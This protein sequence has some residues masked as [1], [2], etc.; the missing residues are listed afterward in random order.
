[1]YLGMGICLLLCAVGS[2]V[3]KTVKCLLNKQVVMCSLIFFCSYTGSSPYFRKMQKALSKQLQSVLPFWI[4]MGGPF[5]FSHRGPASAFGDQ[6]RYSLAEESHK[7]RR[8]PAPTK[9]EKNYFSF[10]G[11]SL[12][13]LCAHSVVCGGGMSGICFAST[14]ALLSMCLSLSGSPPINCS[15]LS[16]SFQTQ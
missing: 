11:W 14:R 3:K 7:G 8:S 15:L 5:N 10:T 6:H 4:W 16:F 9:C 2:G 1:M 12:S 13:N